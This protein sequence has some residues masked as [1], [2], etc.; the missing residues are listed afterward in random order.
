M[1]G[2]RKIAIGYPRWARYNLR[3][4]SSPS[5]GHDWW[6]I[7]R[8][9]NGLLRGFHKNDSSLT[10]VLESQLRIEVSERWVKSLRSKSIELRRI[11]SMNFGQVFVRTKYL[12]CSLTSLKIVMS[13]SAGISPAY[14]ISE[15]QP[16][17]MCKG[18]LSLETPREHHTRDYLA[19]LISACT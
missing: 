3:K 4:R 2:Y 5:P 16:V 15:T 10:R 9:K 6:H 11:E 19:L 13:K 8:P 12:M 18:S 7:I 17:A 1:K 14:L